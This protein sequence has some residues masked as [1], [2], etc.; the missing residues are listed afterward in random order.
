MAALVPSFSLQTLVENAIRHGAAPKVGATEIAITGRVERGR[1][2]IAV[3]DS[4]VGASAA[5]LDDATGT[6]LRRLRERLSVFFA[7]AGR[8]DVVSVPGSGFT[9][10]LVVP[11]EP[12]DAA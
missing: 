9:A 2:T 6:G 7:G 5:Q 10:T 11:A 12:P 1:L 4:G 8:V 3:R